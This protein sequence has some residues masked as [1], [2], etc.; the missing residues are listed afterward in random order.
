MKIARSARLAVALVAGMVSSYP[1][2]AAL[3]AG[4]DKQ[5]SVAAS[6]AAFWRAAE[7]HS[8]EQQLAAWD[9][10]VERPRSDLYASVVWEAP[11]HQDWLVRKQRFLRARFAAYPQLS[12][13]IP[14]EEQALSRVLDQTVPRFR[15]MFPEAS[16]QPP[17]QMLL[18]PNFDAKSGVLADGKPVLIF[19]VDSLL[20]EQA[21]LG[22]VVPHELFHL[23]HAQH[24]G[25]SNDGVMPG[26]ALTVPLFE[27]GLA[28]YVSGQ[29][30]PGY[31]DGAL[32]LQ[33][34]LGGIPAS[35]LAEVA[36]RFLADARFKAIDS[37]HPDAFRK[38]FNAA[39]TPY[40]QD[41]PNRAGY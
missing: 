12:A 27:E 8:F 16:Q 33:A 2:P 41:L 29:L 4:A 31:D 5:P 9:R 1:G 6:F 26:V 28:T 35:R 37:E 20:L 32:L 24:A 39:A 36:R 18:A 7:G 17:V 23:F 34:D 38:W 13:G 22:V 3:A 25:F 30:S 14:A 11:H 10:D 21:D 40:Q 15:R 19:A